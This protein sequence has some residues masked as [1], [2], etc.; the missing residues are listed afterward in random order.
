M[1]TL[2]LLV[3]LFLVTPAHAQIVLSWSWSSEIQE[4]GFDLE[5]APSG[6]TQWSLY[7]RL[8]ADVMSTEDAE[9]TGTCYRVRAFDAVQFYPY[10]NTFVVGGTPPP[11]PPADTEAPKVSILSPVNGATVVRRSTVTIRASFTDNVGVTSVRYFVS[12]TLLTNCG[13]TSAECSWSVPNPPNKTYILKVEARDAAGNV[14]S[15]QVSV[16]SGR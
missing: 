7:Q 12:S 10:S 6:C 14:G 15:A 1:L 5:R 16:R 11:P 2:S 13:G 4:T 8:A 9:V 3:L